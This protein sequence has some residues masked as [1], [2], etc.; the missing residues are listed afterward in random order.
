M[1]AILNKNTWKKIQYWRNKYKNPPNGWALAYMIGEEYEP[2]KRT[3]K[4]ESNQKKA[5]KK[6]LC[7]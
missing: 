4:N 6:T 5:P 2:K 7:L 1:G 3:I